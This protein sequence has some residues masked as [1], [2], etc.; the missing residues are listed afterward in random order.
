MLTYAARN[1]TLR[2]LAGLLLL[3]ACAAPAAAVEAQPQDRDRLNRL[4]Q[5]GASNDAATRAFAEGRTLLDEQKW[6]QAVVTFSKFLADYPTDRNADAAMYW[7][8]YASEKQGKDKQAET[9]LANLLRAHPRSTWAD[10]AKVL[11]VKVRT[12]LGLAPE[13]PQVDD[14]SQLQI[15]ALQALCQNDRAGCAT[16]AAEVLSSSAAPVV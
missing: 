5:T 7:L 3:T 10:D 4:V 12:K 2:V 9:V 6:S 14:K 16:R 11:R 1:L 8:A 13:A 15:I